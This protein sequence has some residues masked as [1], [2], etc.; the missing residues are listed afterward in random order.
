MIRSDH[1]VWLRPKT[2][3]CTKI[4]APRPSDADDPVC[5][6][7]VP[8]TSTAFSPPT[9]HMKTTRRMISKFIVLRRINQGVHDRRFD[10]KVHTRFRSKIDRFCVGCVTQPMAIALQLLLTI[11]LCWIVVWAIY[12]PK[13]AAAPEYSKPILLMLQS[14]TVRCW[15]HCET[16][17]ELFLP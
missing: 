4:T 7:L 3:Y 15:S 14:S 2:I 9:L 1:A 13:I 6:N 10:L 11:S 17:V 16:G 12:P 5:D 8:A